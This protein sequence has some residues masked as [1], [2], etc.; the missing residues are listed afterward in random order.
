MLNRSHLRELIIFTLV[1][2]FNTVAYFVLA[3]VFY[4][5]GLG[6]GVSAY[7]AYGVM[8]PVSFFGHRKLTFASAA[9]VAGQGIRFALVQVCNLL[10]IWVVSAATQHL[11]LPGWI[12]F[13]TISVMIPLFNFIVLRLWVFS[14][15]SVAKG[16]T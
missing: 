13:A 4:I 2:V 5:S 6:R 16:T 9:P 8:L 11:D 10:I 3:N 1:G 12:S 14:H 7:L 15:R